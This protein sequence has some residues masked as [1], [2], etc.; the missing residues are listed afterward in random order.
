MPETKEVRVLARIVGKR[1][2]LDPWWDHR[3]AVLPEVYARLG[4]GTYKGRRSAP[5]PVLTECAVCLEAA[6][7]VVL[8]PCGH[9][10]I[11]GPC[12]DRCRGTCPICRAQFRSHLA[13]I[14]D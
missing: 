8:V 7:L 2:G 4:L 1:L 12:A 3:D 5:A 6:A 13:R 9:R 11:C 10:R 14:Y